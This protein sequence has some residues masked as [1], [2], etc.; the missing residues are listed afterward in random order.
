MKMSKQRT[1][2]I[3]PYTFQSE[4]LVHFLNGFNNKKIRLQIQI[5]NFP[6]KRAA[7]EEKIMLL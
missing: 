3:F 5:L 6:K 2:I 1:K 4:I 7:E